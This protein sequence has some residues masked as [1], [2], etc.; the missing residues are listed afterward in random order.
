MLPSYPTVVALLGIAALLDH[1]PTSLLRALAGMM[2]LLL[3][4]ALP[5]YLLPD[6]IAGGD[7]KLAGVLGLGL[8][9]ASWGALLTGTFLGWALAA[10]SRLPLRAT[11]KVTPDAPIPLGAFLI[12]GALV[13]LLAG[14]VA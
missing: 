1:N 13:A 4:Y 6:A 10:V 14:A 9:W 7:V 3:V 8:G 5:Y 12:T 11:H 2:I